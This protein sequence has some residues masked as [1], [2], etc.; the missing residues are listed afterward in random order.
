MEEVGKGLSG[1]EGDLCGSR[2]R[3]E[4]REGCKGDGRGHILNFSFRFCPVNLV[5]WDTK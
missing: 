2:G 3:G 5:S 4:S 1:T